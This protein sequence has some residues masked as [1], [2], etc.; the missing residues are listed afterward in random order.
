M[1][2]TFAH[3]TWLFVAAFGVAALIALGLRLDRVRRLAIAQFSSRLLRTSMSQPRRVVKRALLAIGIAAVCVALARPERGFRWEEAHRRGVDLLFAI[4]TSKSMLATDTKPSRLARAKLAVG[5][6]AAHF[7]ADRV[8]IVAFAGDAFLQCPL[9]LDRQ[10]FDDTLNAL[11]TD[12]I[13][14]G[15]TDVGRAIETG[16]AAL[17]SQPGRQKILV[18]LTDGED[19]AAHSL[20]A[21]TAAA[22]AGVRVY[23]IGVGTA[24]GELVPLPTGGFARDESGAFV[25]SHLDERALAAI[26]HATGGE[27]RPLGADGGGLEALYRDVLAKLPQEELGSRTHRVPLDRFQWPLGLAILA[28]ALEPLIGDR[29]RRARGNA[30]TAATAVFAIGMCG[31]AHA[32]P[33]SAEKAFHDG[34]FAD[35]AKEY[36]RAATAAPSDSRLTL[37]AGAAAYKSG[38]YAQAAAAFD[39]SL[40][41][42]HVELQQRAYYDLGNAHY[43]IGQASE[44]SQVD[45]TLADWHQ[46]VTDYESAIKL[47]PKDADAIFNRDLVKQKIAALEQQQK[48]P[49][50]QK[51]NQQNQKKQ[52]QKP[53][54]QA[55]NDKQPGQNGQPQNQAGQKPGEQKQNGQPQQAQN[56]AGQKPGEQKQNGQ[57]QQAQNQAGQKPGEQKQNGEPQPGQAAQQKAA[58][59]AD[60]EPSAPR[61]PGQLSKQEAKMLLDSM[62][63]GERRLPTHVAAGNEPNRADDEPVRKDW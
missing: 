36:Q 25:K 62:K 8:G 57:P 39:H 21:A 34:K 19:L 53:N 41:A 2:T 38:D 13:A 30:L 28:F 32:S 59:D 46:A 15:G 10:V 12:I 7:S 47:D 37:N 56:Q 61:A 4:D 54:E 1:T 24:A 51:Q 49:E 23:A 22:K 26:A 55:K 60:D 11:D 16:S 27:Y 42:E 45:K 9:T 48:K 50:Q 29:K 14:R 18:L 17:A 58:G 3:P 40:H 20:E 5:D 52:D 44:K 6:L 35:A 31:A 63:G 43:R 33:A